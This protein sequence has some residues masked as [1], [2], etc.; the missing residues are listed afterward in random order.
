MADLGDLLDIPNRLQPQFDLT[1]RSHIPVRWCVLRPRCRCEG[2]SDSASEH[3]PG[4]CIRR[5]KD[6]EGK[7]GE[8]GSGLVAGGRGE[9]LEG[10][11]RFDDEPSFP[12]GTR[13]I[14]GLSSSQV[15]AVSPIL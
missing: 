5:V 6:G 3:H 7:V 2:R 11:A 4:R 13:Y 9:F 8:L 12:V 10:I 15:L 1:Q 14:N